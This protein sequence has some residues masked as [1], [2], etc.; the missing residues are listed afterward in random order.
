MGGMIAQLMA[1]QHGHK[2]QTL[3][4]IMSTTGNPR[5]PRATPAAMKALTERPTAADLATVLSFGI[6]AARA[7]GS[8]AWPTPEDRLRDRIERD[9]KRSFYPQGAMRQMAAI[10]ADGDRRAR[11]KRITAPTLVI[12][13]EADPLV[14]VEG[15]KDTHAV[16]TGSKLRLFPGMG[17]DLPLELVDDMAAAI[18]EHAR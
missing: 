7:I 8:P 2:V 9:F 4:S 11:L 6:K 17:H 15:G 18:A 16:I 1:V 5:L 10:L 14:P 12:H 3:T 13:G